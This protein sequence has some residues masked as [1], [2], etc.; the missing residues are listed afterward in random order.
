MKNKIKDILNKWIPKISLII[1]VVSPLIDWT[2]NFIQSNFK[3]IKNPYTSWDFHLILIFSILNMIYE[4]VVDKKEIAGDESNILLNR[5]Q[6]DYYEIWEVCKKNR[7]ISID[8]YGHSFKTLWFNFIQKF[9]NDAIINS[10]QYDLIEIRLISTQKGNNCFS[11]IDAFYDRLTSDMAAKIRIRLVEVREVSF[12]TGICVN[13][14]YL[15]LS[16]REPY[17]TTKIN[18]HVRE[19][20]RRNNNT[21]AKML[22]WFLEIM[23]YYFKNC[24]SREVR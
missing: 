8:A 4:Q 11:D 20:K 2:I 6:S 16:I 7:I 13:E 19:W 17:Q 22:D 3:V 15:W 10:K 1:V 21:S 14:D 12:F 24:E 5:N 23:D 9:L 18:E